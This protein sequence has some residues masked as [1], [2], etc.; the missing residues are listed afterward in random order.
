MSPREPPTPAI[1]T[2]DRLWSLAESNAALPEVR[3]LLA[4]ARTRLRDVRD[5]E[6]QLQDLRT[7]W[8]DQVLAVACPDHMEWVR[9]RDAHHDARAALL[10]ALSKLD[11]LGVEVKDLDSGLVDFRGML[12]NEEVYLCWRE[13]E[14]SVAHYHPTTSGFAGRKPIPRTALD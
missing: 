5:C 10:G 9:W 12:G 6:A 1:A 14:A 8:G 3:A 4:D 2:G 13:G 7:V 11:V